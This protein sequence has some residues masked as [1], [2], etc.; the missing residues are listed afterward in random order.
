MPASSRVLRID[1]AIEERGLDA[2]WLPPTSDAVP[3]LA[4]Q[5]PMQS[6]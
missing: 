5:E 3:G 1:P 2:M 6:T 4:A